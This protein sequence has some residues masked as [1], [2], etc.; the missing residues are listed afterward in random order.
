MPTVQEEI[1]KIQKRLHDG[2]AIWSAAELLR[3]WREARRT[4]APTCS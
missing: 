1:T 3:L 2:A 4:A